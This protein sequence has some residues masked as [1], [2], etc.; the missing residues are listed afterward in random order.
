[1]KRSSLVT[2]LVFLLIAVG[3]GWMLRTPSPTTP[4]V[5]PASVAGKEPSPQIS[6]AERIEPATVEPTAAA[7]S[8]PSVRPRTE[9]PSPPEPMEEIRAEIENLQVSF[10]DFR[11]VLGENP[12]GTNAEITHALIGNNARQL[13]V[14]I[15]AGSS[16]NADG[17]MCDRWGTP[18]FSTNSPRNKWK[19]IPPAWI[20]RWEPGTIWW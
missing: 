19:S 6:P 10:R 12:V 11:T 2:A 14:T 15:P 5:P 13:R 18:Y 7:E 3:V 16:V 9:P 4:A 17:E 1:M 8:T 20:A